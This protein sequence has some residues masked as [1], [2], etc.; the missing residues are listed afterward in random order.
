M[1]RK[2]YFFTHIVKSS[3]NI[4]E[5][6]VSQFF[7]TITQPQTGQNTFMKSKLVIMLTI[8]LGA[9]G[10]LSSFTLVL[11][12]KAYGQISESFRLGFS[13]LISAK[14]TSGS[15]KWQL[16]TGRWGLTWNSWSRIYTSISTWTLSHYSERAENGDLKDILLWN[17]S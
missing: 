17:L 11:E 4:Y 8:I 1:R 5:S 7:R 9:I 16:K 13:E 6:S 3:A 15:S 12:E 10:I 2:Q 14:D